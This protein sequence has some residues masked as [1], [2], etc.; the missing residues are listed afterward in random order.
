ME[1]GFTGLVI[2]DEGWTGD[3]CKQRVIRGSNPFVM[4]L[5]INGPKVQAEKSTSAKL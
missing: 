4:Q 2:V 1:A 5:P 3:F